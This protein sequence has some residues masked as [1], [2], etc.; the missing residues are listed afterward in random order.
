MGMGYSANEVYTVSEEFIKEICQKEFD[1]FM[2][3]LENDEVEFDDFARHDA[4]ETIISRKTN[5]DETMKHTVAYVELC[6]VFQEKTGLSLE[7][8]YHDQENDG[9]RYDEIGG[10]VWVVG[11]VY[12]YTPAGEKYKDKIERKGFVVFG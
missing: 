7:V 5:D 1:N 6:L 12:Q 11:D 3:E 10:I 4:P 9:D 2:L 8:M